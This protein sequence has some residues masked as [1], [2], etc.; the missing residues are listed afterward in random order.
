MWYAK[1]S[2]RRELKPERTRAERLNQFFENARW[3]FY[4]WWPS[5]SL[6]GNPVLWREWHRNQP[7][8]IAW[9][10][11]AI[12]WI[13]S[14]LS[15][16]YGIYEI[17]HDGLSMG[18][19]GWTLPTN[20]FMVAFGMLF[21][22]ATAPT[23]LS[24]ERVRGSLDLLMSTPLSTRT[25]VLGKW[26][27]VFRVVP[28]LAVIP[29]LGALMFTAAAPVAMTMTPG[30][31][32]AFP[33]QYQVLTF[34]DRINAVAFPVAW[35]FANGA[36][37]TSVGLALATWIERPGRAIGASVAFYLFVLIGFPMLIGTLIMPAIIHSLSL[38]WGDRW[39]QALQM[40]L[41]SV[42]PFVGQIASFEWIAYPF[43]GS[44]Q[45][46]WVF[47]SLELLATFALAGLV[48]VFTI[49]TFDSRLGRVSEQPARE[50]WIE[51]HPIGSKQPWTPRRRPAAVLEIPKDA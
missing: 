7:S 27:A 5:P 20:A 14:T 26:W 28:V 19:L 29:A 4:S 8:R 22:S 31:L 21:L 10:L 42:S 9:R 46:L 34:S 33:N 3:R 38:S 24:E 13:A 35:I 50:A 51:L 41:M 37:F 48:L 25:I 39:I 2:L 47:Q 11:W 36:L 49:L 23:A 18:S 45:W 43:R 12:F 15:A 30:M 44:P 6:D 32:A 16:S 40:G 1:W 17:L